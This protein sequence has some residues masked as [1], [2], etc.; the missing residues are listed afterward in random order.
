VIPKRGKPNSGDKPQRRS[1]SR[2]RPPSSLRNKDIVSLIQRFIDSV[3]VEDTRHRVAGAG[4]FGE[5]IPSQHPRVLKK[6]YPTRQQVENAVGES[7]HPPP[8]LESRE[9]DRCHA[10]WQQGRSLDPWKAVL[11]LCFD[12]HDTLLSISDWW[13]NPASE[14]VG[15]DSTVWERRQKYSAAPKK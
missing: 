6:P 15:R 3:V 5:V 12:K 13:K 9:G 4:G 7:E 1:D 14:S 2:T 11:R 10:W 8:L